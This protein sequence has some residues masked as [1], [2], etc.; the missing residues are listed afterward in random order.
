MKQAL[1][2]GESERCQLCKYPRIKRAKNCHVIYACNF[3]YLILAFVVAL[4]FMFIAGLFRVVYLL[5]FLMKNL[6][7][8]FFWGVRGFCACVCV[9]LSSYIFP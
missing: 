8:T 1:S 7:E 9:E 3:L 4:V 6:I 2:N 5:G